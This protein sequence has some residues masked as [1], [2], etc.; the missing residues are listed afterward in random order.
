MLSKHLILATPFSFCLQFFQHQSLFQLSWH[1]FSD[2]FTDFDIQ[3][4]PYFLFLYSGG[5]E[6]FPSSSST[7]PWKWF[8]LETVELWKKNKLKSNKIWSLSNNYLNTI[9][10]NF[11]KLLIPWRILLIN[12]FKFIYKDENHLKMGVLLYYFSLVNVLI[13]DSIL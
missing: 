11:L 5:Q 8:Y 10:K 1:Q 6:K 4:F 9:S 7:T 13:G 2:I 12:Y 3:H